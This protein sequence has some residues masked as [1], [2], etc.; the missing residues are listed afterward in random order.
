MARA[1]RDFDSGSCV[2]QGCSFLQDLHPTIPHCRTIASCDRSAPAPGDMS[3]KNCAAGKD[4]CKWCRRSFQTTPNP[5]IADP[6]PKDLLKRL[7]PGSKECR[8]CRNISTTEPEYKNLSTVELSENMQ[9]EVSG[10]TSRRKSSPGSVSAVKANDEEALVGLRK[11]SSRPKNP[12]PS[13]QRRCLGICGLSLCS[14]STAWNSHP[15]ASPA[16][17]MPGKR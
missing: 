9:G 6:G 5:V 10:G 16:S 4:A 13:R 3:S 17:A 11:R 14:K 15:N 12:R 2:V 1:S 8:S 7:A